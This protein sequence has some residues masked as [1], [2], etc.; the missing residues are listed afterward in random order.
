MTNK[1]AGGWACAAL[2]CLGVTAWAGESMDGV[3]VRGTGTADLGIPGHPQMSC[4]RGEGRVTLNER[5]VEI[6]DARV[7]CQVGGG[8]PT[9]LSFVPERFEIA[10]ASLL[11]DGIEVGTIDTD[12]I[13]LRRSYDG[14]TLEQTFRLAD[15]KVR[16]R[17]RATRPDGAP[18]VT[19]DLSFERAP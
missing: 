3:W 2:L 13:T 18:G 9:I 16:Y 4:A 7:E 11:R 5:S 19:I 8:Y 17:Y 6:S 10:G 1:L 15:G 12:G 14:Q